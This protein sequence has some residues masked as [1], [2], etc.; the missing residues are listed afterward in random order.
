L[1]AAGIP[2]GMV[3]RKFGRDYS[4]VAGEIIDEVRKGGYSTVVMGRWGLGPI[5]S[6]ILGSV[7]NS[8]VHHARGFTVTI[9]KQMAPLGLRGKLIQ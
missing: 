9:V 6:A 2:A 4:S 1:V 8:V 3:T 5:K 7:T